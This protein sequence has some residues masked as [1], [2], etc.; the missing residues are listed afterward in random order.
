MTGLQISEQ[1]GE[2]GVRERALDWESGRVRRC[3]SE[4]VT[5]PLWALVSLPL[6]QVISLNDPL[7][8]TAWAAAC[9]GR[10]CMN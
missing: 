5:S 6:K 7:V 2:P 8:L 3:D 4:H 9:I 10:V 1:C